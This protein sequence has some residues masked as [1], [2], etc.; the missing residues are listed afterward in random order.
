MTITIHTSH[1]FNSLSVTEKIAFG[2]SVVTLMTTNVA[3]FATPKVPLATLTTANTDLHTKN[4]AFVLNGESARPA[5][6]NS[7]KNWIKLYRQQAD[8][9]DGVANGDAA[10]IALSGFKQTK[11]ESSPSE[12][13]GICA[14]S[15]FF[16]NR[17]KGSIHVQT[18]AIKG[19]M[20][21]VSIISNQEVGIGVSGNQIVI[22]LGDKIVS[23]VVDTHRTVDHNGLPS[24]V[25]MN[26]TIAAFNRASTGE[27]T[28]NVDVSVL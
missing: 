15:D 24:H 5:L 22:K 18:D 2:P 1:D 14:N 10:I 8:H 28:P 13:P 19:A 25:D 27:F 12:K 16:A 26:A 7:Q 20:G 17:T 21:Y 4:D 3:T 6:L 11:S 9:V 23:I